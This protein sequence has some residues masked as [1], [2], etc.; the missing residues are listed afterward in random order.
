MR[1]SRGPMSDRRAV[2]QSVCLLLI[3]VL[4]MAVPTTAQVHRVAAMN[5]E[6]IRVLDRA[7]TVVILPGGILEQHGPYLPTYTD[8]YCNERL[9]QAVAEAVAARPGWAALV[10]P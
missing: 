7:R 6:Q 5:T 8:G 9:A 2:G 10:F 4:G 3:L 1:S